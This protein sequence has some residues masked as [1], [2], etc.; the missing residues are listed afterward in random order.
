MTTDTSVEVS[1]RMTLPALLIVGDVV[2]KSC[3][4]VC[5]ELFSSYLCG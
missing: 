3:P 4:R 2:S 1:T 5:D